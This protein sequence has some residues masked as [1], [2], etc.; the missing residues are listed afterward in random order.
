MRPI[1]PT[2]AWRLTGLPD[3][4]ELHALAIW[5]MSDGEYMEAPCGKL[6]PWA[7]YPE[8]IGRAWWPAR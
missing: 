1:C 5:L 3:D 7:A 4:G 2:I 6:A 8:L